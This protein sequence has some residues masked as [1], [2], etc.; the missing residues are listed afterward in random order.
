MRKGYLML[1]LKT[2]AFPKAGSTMVLAQLDQRWLSNTASAGTGP[3]ATLHRVDA[4][5]Q[6]VAERKGWLQATKLD[7]IL[8]VSSRSH[9]SVRS[10]IRCWIAFVGRLCLSLVLLGATMDGFVIS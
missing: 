9:K 1:V 10:G 5:F 6:S 3:R 4:G 8:G 7:A 2:S